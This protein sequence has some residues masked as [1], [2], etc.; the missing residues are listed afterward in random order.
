MKEFKKL[1]NIT[2]ENRL[3]TFYNLSQLKDIT[4]LKTRA[5]KYRML[6]VKEKYKDV[7]NLL[8]KVG[9]EWR[10]HYTLV[11]EFLPKYNTGTK[12]IYNHNWQTFTTWNPK[13]NYTIEYHKQLLNEIK[14]KLPNNTIVYTIEKDLRGVNHVH[15][16]SDATKETMNQIV[17]GT[18]GQY[19]DL[20][21]DCRI[22]TNTLNNKFSVIEYIKKASQDGGVL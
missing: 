5:L 13:N 2:N 4:G 14:D 6:I 18:L 21:F 3:Q 10:L 12:T 20:A 17:E 1:I 11:N 7:P 16:V 19:L 22:Q 15:V 8:K 9:R